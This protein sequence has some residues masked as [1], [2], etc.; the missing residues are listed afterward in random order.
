M[1]KRIG[2]SPFVYTDDGAKAL[3]VANPDGSN[4]DLAV[5]FASLSAIPTGFVGTARVGT[6]LYAGDGTS[7]V[8]MVNPTNIR[9]NYTDTSATPGSV[10]NNSPR[11]KASMVAN[12][13]SPI[14]ITNSLV[15]ATSSIFIIQEATDNNVYGLYVVPAA[16]SFTVNFGM[17][18]VLAPTTNIKFSFLVVN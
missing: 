8:K 3:S 9:A 5:N 6:D 14:T 12:V 17:G 7:V 16:G 10:T 13:L 1:T 11:G 4:S 18:T 2:C 15:T